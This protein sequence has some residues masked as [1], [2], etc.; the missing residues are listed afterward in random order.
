MEMQTFSCRFE[1]GKT[2]TFLFRENFLAHNSCT[3]STDESSLMDED[4]EAFESMLPDEEFLLPSNAVRSTRRAK[5]S[6][7]DELKDQKY[8]ERRRINNEQAKRSRLKA[9]MQQ[10][11]QRAAMEQLILDN[12]RLV[13][14]MNQLQETMMALIGQVKSNAVCM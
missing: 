12:Q 9:K 2:P 3:M 11:A 4:W 7:S 14:E 13:M 8:H 6:V 10:Q 5:V 1:S